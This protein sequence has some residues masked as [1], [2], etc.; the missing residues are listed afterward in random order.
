MLKDNPIYGSYEPP[1]MSIS[2][3]KQPSTSRGK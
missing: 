2:G 3:I 1:S